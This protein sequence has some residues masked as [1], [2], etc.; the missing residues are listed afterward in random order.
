MMQAENI[1]NPIDTPKE[2]AEYCTQHV[3]SWTRKG[4]FDNTKLSSEDADRWRTSNLI[5][6]RFYGYMDKW[7]HGY[8]DTST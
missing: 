7:I 8:M 5:E 4:E 3:G 1:S 6:A 2:S